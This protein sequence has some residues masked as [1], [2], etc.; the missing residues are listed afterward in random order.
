MTFDEYQQ[1]MLSLL[2]ALHGLCVVGNRRAESIAFVD[3]ALQV[4]REGHTASEQ[5]CYF[6][7]IDACLDNER[8]IQPSARVFVSISALS[9]DKLMSCIGTFCRRFPDQVLIELQHSEKDKAAAQAFHLD[10]FAL[11]FRHAQHSVHD[12]MEYQLYEYRLKNYK[13]AP[14][15]LNSRFWAHPERFKLLE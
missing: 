3:R 5:P 2:G 8:P 1:E 10:C 15:W 11:G 13:Q 7:D 4:E 14:D 12:G 6:S 9:I